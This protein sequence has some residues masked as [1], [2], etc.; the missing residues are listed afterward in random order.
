MEFC[1][2]RVSRQVQIPKNCDDLWATIVHEIPGLTSYREKL[3]MHYIDDEG[4]DICLT[5]DDE[6]VEA[7]DC[8]AKTSNGFLSLKLLLNG[9]EPKVFAEIEDSALIN[10]DS[11]DE[12]DDQEEDGYVL[13]A[14]PPTVPRRS[15]APDD[16]AT[17]E[18]TTDIL[19]AMKD[20]GVA[21]VTE[22]NSALASATTEINNVM[23]QLAGAN[24]KQKQTK[25]ELD[26]VIAELAE[27]T[28]KC[29][30]SEQ[31]VVKLTHEL[32]VT[33][34][35][36]SKSTE[37]AKIT[38]I[39]VKDLEKQAAE[40]VMWENKCKAVEQERDQLGKQLQDLRTALQVLTMSN[41][42]TPVKA[43]PVT[44]EIVS[45]EIIPPSPVVEPAPAPELPPAYENVAV[46]APGAS[47]KE[48]KQLQQLLDMGFKL[49][50]EEMNEKLHAHGG[51]MEHVI[52]S[53]LF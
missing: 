5:T 25:A 10:D 1:F 41:K 12:E 18:Q 3:Q 29:T 4:D 2:G 26:S 43:T 42:P 15:R 22:I 28:S 16:N 24:T 8:G 27:V 14:V 50:V 13:P 38:S 36:L 32:E 40:K 31:Q 9:V 20:A 49:T 48:R 23:D 33:K 47:A 44:A 17:P 51:S 39:R 6:F 37:E 35:S 34:A 19:Q 30:D 21:A 52:Q 11:T 45:N 53:L 7:L 46:V